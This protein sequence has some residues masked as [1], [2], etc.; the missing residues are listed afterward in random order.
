[1]GWKAFTAPLC[2]QLL[3]FLLFVR[4]KAGKSVVYRNTVSA[5]FITIAT[6]RW[7]DW[8]LVHFLKSARLQPNQLFR[9]GSLVSS[10]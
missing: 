6:P 2:A 10:L 1:M 9:V 8:G 5:L 3:F 7:G 4:E